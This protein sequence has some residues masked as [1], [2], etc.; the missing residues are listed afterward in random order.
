MKD[1]MFRETLASCSRCTQACLYVFCFEDFHTTLPAMI[2]ITVPPAHYLDVVPNSARQ[3]K[4]EPEVCTNLQCENNPSTNLF[5]KVTPSQ[6]NPS[7]Q[8]KMAS[9]HVLEIGRFRAT[10][11]ESLSHYLNMKTMSSDVNIS[12]YNIFTRSFNVSHFLSS[13]HRVEGWDGGGGQFYD[14]V[15][16]KYNLVY[17]DPSYIFL[18]IK[19]GLSKMQNS[20]CQTEKSLE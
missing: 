3:E 16:K 1:L 15:P 2:S 9:G 6:S 7:I 18:D 5:R 17:G 8:I 10:T 19:E 11:T 14:R 4:P 20:R 13:I 12:H